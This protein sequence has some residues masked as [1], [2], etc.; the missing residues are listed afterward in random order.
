MVED[1]RVPITSETPT[2]QADALLQ[3][4]LRAYVTE[5]VPLVDLQTWFSANYPDL[6]KLSGDESEVALAETSLQEEVGLLLA[7]YDAGQWDEPDVRDL[8]SAYLI[9]GS[10][11]QALADSVLERATGAPGLQR[12]LRERFG[13]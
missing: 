8:I 11:G 12:E 9:G 4:Q 6:I 13:L 10:A 7:E 2:V 1:N 5:T 3:R